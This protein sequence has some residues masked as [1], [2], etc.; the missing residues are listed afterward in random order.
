MD[1]LVITHS[2]WQRPPSAS[3]CRVPCLLQRDK[4][5]L[6]NLPSETSPQHAS[7]TDHGHTVYCWII[8]TIVESSE[9]VPLWGT[10]KGMKG[11][12][13]LFN[14]ET[15][16][17]ASCSVMPPSF[18]SFL[19]LPEPFTLPRLL[20]SCGRWGKLQGANWMGEDGRVITILLSSVME[21]LD[22]AKK[23]KRD[24]EIER[25]RDREI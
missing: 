21:P 9:R 16:S 13:R 24:R 12:Q 2:W 19:S 15:V 4:F 5:L 10:H 23:T 25:E 1:L 17:Q 3:W 7:L 6:K 20:I 18:S 8:R 14:L 22:S 11:A